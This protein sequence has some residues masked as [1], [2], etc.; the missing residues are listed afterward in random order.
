M[1]GERASGG[2]C[3][4][5]AD[6]NLFYTRHRTPKGCGGVV[7]FA[8]VAFGSA[9]QKVFRKLLQQKLVEGVEGVESEVARLDEPERMPKTMLDASECCIIY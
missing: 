4:G 6:P 8:S 9:M 7:F 3:G 1:L 5:I 2:E